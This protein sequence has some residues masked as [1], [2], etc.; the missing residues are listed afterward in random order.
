MGE[1]Y[2][3][4]EFMDILKVLEIAGKIAINESKDGF[5]LSDLLSFLTSDEFKVAFE[6]AI[7]GADQVDDEIKDLDG[8][9]VFDLSI[10]GVMIAKN[11]YEEWKKAA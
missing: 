1:Q 3:T 2:G 4:K 9:E 10:A 7:E 8:A 6:Q 11:L 5:Q